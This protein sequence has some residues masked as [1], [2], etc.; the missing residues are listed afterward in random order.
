MGL[1]IVYLSPTAWD[2]LVSDATK[3]QWRW[4]EAHNNVGVSNYIN[5]LFRHQDITFEDTRPQF[6]K[7][8]PAP[9]HE[10]GIGRYS[11]HSPID[12][13]ELLRHSIRVDP[14]ALARAAEIATTLMIF[15][16]RGAHYGIP[17]KASY[18]LESI[19]N[20]FLT[21]IGSYEKHLFN[22]NPVP[23]MHH[24]PRPATFEELN[25]NM[26]DQD[27]ITPPP[28]PGKRGR[29]PGQ[30]NNLTFDA[31]GLKEYNE[32]ASQNGKPLLVPSTLKVQRCF[33]LSISATNQL[34]KEAAYYHLTPSQYLTKF[35]E[36]EIPGLILK[37]WTEE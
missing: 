15:P 29:P 2:N 34:D 10:W 7:D 14:R 11:D 37:T 20:R 19:G 31:K 3:Y 8:L 18:T 24:R 1:E 23:I 12:H 33:S 25:L 26:Y 28:I 27:N 5:H 30:P 22:P 13:P 35:L 6:L 17:A 4:P 36:M 9:L 16:S 21:P 32:W